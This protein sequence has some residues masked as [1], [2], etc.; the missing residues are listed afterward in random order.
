M[1]GIY[2]LGSRKNLAWSCRK[3]KESLKLGKGQLECLLHRRQ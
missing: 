2:N 1:D 3:E